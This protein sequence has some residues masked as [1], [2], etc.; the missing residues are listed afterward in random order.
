MP[1]VAPLVM[2][3]PL[4]PAPSDSAAAYRDALMAAIRQGK[5]AS[6]VV[7]K[8]RR[9]FLDA[10]ERFQTRARDW[11]KQADQVARKDPALAARARLIISQAQTAAYEIMRSDWVVYA[12]DHKGAE[13][14]ADTSKMNALL[15][16]SPFNTNV[17]PSRPPT[18]SSRFSPPVPQPSYDESRPFREANERFQTRVRYWLNLED[19]VAKQD[20]RLAAHGRQIIAQ[21][22]STAFDLGRT[23]PLNAAAASKIDAL[24]FESPF[25]P[26]ASGDGTKPSFSPQPS[27]KESRTFWEA[28][29]RFQS[30]AR[31]WL[32]QV[33]LVAKRDP[34]LASRA[35]QT[36]EQAKLTA[37]GL[38]RSVPFNVAD[39]VKMDALLP[40]SPVNINAV[41]TRPPT[42]TPA[43]SRFSPLV[44]QPSSDD[45][46]AFW[47][48]N[49]RFQT[50]VRYWLTQADQV[51]KQDAKLAARARQIIS[52]AQSTAF[53]LGRTRPLN[54]AATNKMN[55]LLSEALFNTNT[56]P[57]G[58]SVVAP[59]ANRPAP[60]N[61]PPPS[62]RPPPPNRPRPPSPTRA[63]VSLPQSL[64][65]PSPPV[66]TRP[67]PPTTRPPPPTTRPPPPTTRPPIA[68]SAPAA[69]RPPP[70]EVPAAPELPPSDVPAAPELPPSDVPAAP[71]LPQSDVPAAP[72][73]PPS[74][75]PAAPE[76]PNEAP[77]F[78]TPPPPRP[79]TPQPPTHTA[80]TKQTDVGN[81]GDL[82]AA[83]RQ[84]K[85]LKKVVRSDSST[86]SASAS[87]SRS[88]L[89]KTVNN[90]SLQAEI[91][92]KLAARRAAITGEKKSEYSDAD[93]GGEA[94]SRLRHGSRSSHKKHSHLNRARRD[95]K[96]I[97][98]HRS[99][100]IVR[101]GGG[102]AGGNLQL[103]VVPTKQAI[104]WY[105]T[106]P[107]SQLK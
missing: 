1:E 21:A 13:F 69:A 59:A 46:R 58:P 25:N 96:Q 61:H 66:A 79:S 30:R 63:P 106:T 18:I 77:S 23:L 60:P 38:G 93:F 7:T 45:S 42:P 34:E 51:A 36:I 80:V 10:E 22:L 67:P 81:R 64:S 99:R 94:R 104:S 105:L 6:R 27:S 29:E 71:E 5:N 107:M 28:N 75:V 17:G 11:L 53:D 95:L 33:K 54:T 20:V 19:Q 74:D 12:R 102:G 39:T 97:L 70:A 32:D 91:A 87:S 2:Q 31:T 78:V 68:P 86:P 37:S 90:S 14:V 8:P 55:T 85:N 89:D 40:E 57:N 82:L 76:L 73:L 3:R 47:E 43:P 26:N 50:R 16:E 98:A 24:L 35:R 84:G 103:S 49:E 83:I 56:A 65:K 101:T 44:P 88:A 48:A 15:S 62:N 72:E 41:P 92:R 4:T 100:Q 52:R 9:A